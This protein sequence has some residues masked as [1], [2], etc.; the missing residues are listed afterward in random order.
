MKSVFLDEDLAIGTYRFA[1]SKLIPDLTRA[2]AKS[3]KDTLVYSY[4][5]RDFEKEYGTKYQKPG[6]FARI[7]VFLVRIMPRIG[8]F[9]TLAFDPPTPEAERLFLESFAR[10]RTRYR[11]LLDNVKANRLQLANLD[12]DTGQPTR[13]GEYPLAD[14]TYADLAKK[15]IDRKDVPDAIRQDINRFY[16]RP[17]LP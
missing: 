5:R 13:R 1:V 12:F 17:A 7:L 15:L 11:G 10:A 3:N 4:T 9:R 6:F 2:A 8:P 16:G 14:E